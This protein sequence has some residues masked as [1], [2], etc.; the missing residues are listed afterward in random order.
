MYDKYGASIGEWVDP[1]RGLARAKSAS[2]KDL[3]EATSNG[4]D[5]RP[6]IV[7]RLDKETSG[8]LLIAKN[9]P[10]FDYLKKIFKD[11]TIKKTYVAL[12]Y[13]QV[14]EKTGVID[15][16]LGK[17][18]IKQSTKISGKRELTE[19]AAVT[20]YKVLKKFKDY[21]LLELRPQTGRTHQIRVHLKSIGHPIVCDPLYAGKRHACPPAL[22]RM[23]LHA[24]KL[25]FVSPAG[26]A[27]TAESDLPPELSVFL[28]ILPKKED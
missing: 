14:K 3:G 24:Q 22:G 15:T 10:A 19:K 4:V 2:P 1:A 27:I 9:Q 18:G 16:P 8:L 13:G 20:E 5:L 25:A 11:R 6:G 26:A 21:T 28:E 23:F 12:V 7:H 17:L